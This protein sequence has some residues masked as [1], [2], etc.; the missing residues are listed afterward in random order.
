M[1]FARSGT[2]AILT[3]AM[4]G[5]FAH[6]PAPAQVRTES[7][8]RPVIKDTR[9]D[10][11]RNWGVS[12]GQPAADL[13]CREKGYER[14]QSFVG[15]VPGGGQTL[16]FGDGR[17]CIGPFC[18]AFSSIICVAGRPAPAQPQA[19]VHTL[20]PQQPLQPIPQSP[21][22]QAMV[23]GPPATPGSPETQTPVITPPKPQAPVVTAPK[24]QAPVVTPPKPQAPVVTAPKPQAP[25]GP[26]VRQ[27]QQ[28]TTVA[29][30]PTI[31]L[32]PRPRP[33]PEPTAGRP[34]AT[35]AVGLAP[36]AGSPAFVIPNYS[37]AQVVSRW[38]DV[39]E[40]V[41]DLPG[42][43]SLF[44]CTGDCSLPLSHDLEVDPAADDQTVHLRWSVTAVPH[45]G[46]ALAQVTSFPFPAFANGSAQDLDPRGL[47]FGG[48]DNGT[49]GFLSF[50]MRALAERLPAGATKAIF[51]V[52]ILPMA[53]SGLGGLVG[54]PSNTI[55]IYYGV[56]TPEPEPWQF[57]E[58][59]IVAEA[60]PVELVALEFKPSRTVDW[61]PGCV[62]WEEYRDSLKKNFFEKV[63]GAL[64][65]MWNF[66]AE[67]YQW[68]KNKVVELA[69]V[70]TFGAVPEEVLEFA[71]NSALAS[72]G[73]P[74]DIPNLDEMISGGLDHLAAEMADVAVSQIP[75]GDLGPTLENLAA[76]IAVDAV[77]A[78]GEEAA[79]RRLRR[80]LEKQSRT[81]LVQAVDEM[82][83]AASNAGKKKT[84]CSGRFIPASYRVT[85]RNAGPDRLEDIGIGI[86][87]SQG[88]YQ[89]RSES[90]SIDPGQ[91][92]SFVTVTEP[93]LRDVW[94]RRLVRMEPMATN[95]NIS[96]WWTEWLSKV[97][98][99]I[100][101]SLPGHR[102]C[103]GSCVNTTLIAHTAPPQLMTRPYAMAR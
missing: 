14:A 39:L 86:I 74:P 65:G 88:I 60:P 2:T 15:P 6:D 53:A 46:A 100:I 94:D 82:E 80:E 4:V 41:R 27:P 73:I 33:D 77:L 95:E 79:R 47:A 97:P 45:A 23:P 52:R 3:A 49:R 25:A 17:L 54:R 36:A 35:P 11:C 31:I 87:D 5:L 26:A 1:A 29:R 85:V 7:F 58:P 30:T 81:A 22:G 84:P 20:V 91:V 32:P 12:C 67:A 10:F 59:E 24:P 37:A 61:P 98:S 38:M 93:K 13:F 83:K 16:V 57:Y 62:E 40:T 19:P 89:N 102:E 90:V 72:A 44:H 92:L 56:A 70:L 21:A 8:L 101:V 96:H 78:E 18:A 9:L 64:K 68:A 63:G 34:A 75:A 69:S 50:D 55:R 42:G 99:S 28:P 43:A 66:A 103:L 48:R 76:D 71:L 51:N